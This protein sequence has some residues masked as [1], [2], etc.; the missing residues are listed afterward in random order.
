MKRI[1]Q[2]IASLIGLSGGI[3]GIVAICIK[4]PRPTA[5]FDYL[6]LLVGIL[7]L[8]VLFTV[9]WQIYTLIDTQKLRRDYDD[10]NSKLESKYAILDK[11]LNYNL[12]LL[13]AKRYFDQG[14]VI[15]RL[16]PSSGIPYILTAL[17]EIVEIVEDND[18]KEFYDTILK[19]LKDL[20]KAM[21][22]TSE[23][24]DNWEGLNNEMLHEVFE[25]VIKI[26]DPEL[27]DWYNN[28]Q[29]EFDKRSP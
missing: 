14:S 5:D 20:I 11:K 4:A 1:F 23:L 27:I 15:G 16:K 18:G 29:K 21:K 28:L 9:G 24:I 7:S 26:K 19:N 12:K 17:G 6:G 10:L 3:C 2:I 8:L 25:L 13:S 22:S